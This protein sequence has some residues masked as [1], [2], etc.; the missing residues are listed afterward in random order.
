VSTLTELSPPGVGLALAV[1]LSDQA[2]EVR[3]AA[4]HGLRELV[5]VL[6]ADEAL[7]TALLAAGINQDPLIRAAVLD[8]LRELRIGDR[9]GYAE[10]LADPRA[11]VRL[12]AVHGLVSVSAADLLA[13]AATDPSREVRVAVAAGIGAL[14]DPR[15]AEALVGLAGDVDPLVQEQALIAAAALG[16]PPPFPRLAV[17]AL[18]SPNWRVRVGGATALGGADRD[19]G[20]DPLRSALRDTNLD[21]RKAA[22]QALAP[23]SGDPTVDTALRAACDDIDADVRAYARAAL[24]RVNA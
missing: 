4:A 23:W 5:S 16:C 13:N 2:A 18:R 24:E 3:A 17:E 11:D 6:D 9:A 21:V 8:L 10:G 14:A 20:G 1:T 7:R 12:S 15:A 19:T 22:V